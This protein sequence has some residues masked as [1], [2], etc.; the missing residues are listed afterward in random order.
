MVFG[1]ETSPMLLLEPTEIL[2][3]MSWDRNGGS[4]W[5][6]WHPAGNSGE[7]L[8]AMPNIFFET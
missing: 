7:I 3:G 5:L 1:K 4:R 8:Q 6:Y 2:W